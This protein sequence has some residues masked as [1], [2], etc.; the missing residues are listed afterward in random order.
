MNEVPLARHTEAPC[1]HGDGAMSSSS[2]SEGSIL[3][4]WAVNT[5]R[6]RHKNSRRNHCHCALAVLSVWRFLCREAR[7]KSTF[8]STV[9]RPLVI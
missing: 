9:F 5:W 6:S 8:R 2:A 4:W 3:D 1:Q 7:N